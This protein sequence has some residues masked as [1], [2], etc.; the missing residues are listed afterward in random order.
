MAA[1]T[2]LVLVTPLSLQQKTTMQIVIS[3]TVIVFNFPDDPDQPARKPEPAQP[4]S[5]YE[6]LRWEIQ[7]GRREDIWGEEVKEYGTI[8]TQ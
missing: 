1:G 7:H 8:L 3:Q 5:L 6:K 2:G 4:S